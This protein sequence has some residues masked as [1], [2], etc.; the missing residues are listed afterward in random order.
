MLNLKSTSGKAIVC[1]GVQGDGKHS[2]SAAAAGILGIPGP[3]RPG[4]LGKPAE[5]GRLTY[6]RRPDDKVGL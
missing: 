3:V 4:E 1:G 2:A 6:A 5:H